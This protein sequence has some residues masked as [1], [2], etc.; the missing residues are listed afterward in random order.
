MKPTIEEMYKP[1]IDRAVSRLLSI[2]AGA[3]LMSMLSGCGEEVE[4]TL[5][6]GEQEVPLQVVDTHIDSE[7]ITRASQ[8]VTSGSMGVFR[9]TGNGYAAQYNVEYNCNNSV[10]TPKD[11][12]NQISLDT[13]QAKL[14]A[15]YP[16]G[17]V[18][19]S[20]QSFQAT[21]EAQKYD[22]KKDMQYAKTGGDNVTS[23]TP[24]ATFAMSHAYS[25][26]KLSIKRGTSYQGSCSIST[27]NLKVGNSF[28]VRRNV[29]LTTGGYYSPP[30]VSGGWDYTFDPAIIINSNG[31]NTDYD[32][33]VPPQPVSQGLTITL[34]IDGKRR[35]VTI[36]AS[37]FNNKLEEGKLYAATLLIQDA[38]VTIQGTVTVEDYAEDTTPIENTP[39]TTIIK[40]I[41]YDNKYLEIL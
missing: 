11:P 1:V 13:R 3:L 16:I 20:N 7:I 5:P 36:P 41:L 18:T 39:D 28:T 38:I 17:S 31:V 21:L 9:T 29:D 24:T 22:V 26:I 8:K 14:C 12:N 27:V 19:I 40:K 4:A 10:W 2:L 15:Y 37:G 35:A 32:V 33:L 34:T 6:G 23:T 25:R 30:P